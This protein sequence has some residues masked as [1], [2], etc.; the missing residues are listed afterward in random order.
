MPKHS[1]DRE[2]L[3]RYF[4]G[5]AS[6][7]ECEAV[8]EKY[9]AVYSSLEAFLR[10]ED[11]VID[12][13]VRGALNTS[14]R[15]LFE[16]NFLCTTARRQRLEFTKSLVEA[17]AG[18]ESSDLSAA[19]QESQTRRSL[20]TGRSQNEVKTT[21]SSVTLQGQP[22]PD[23][24][25]EWFENLLQWLD[26]VRERA[27]EKY[28]RIRDSLIRIFVLGGCVDAEDLADETINRVSLR[29]AQLMGTY[30]GDPAQYFT[31]VARSV[32]QESR[33]A[34]ATMPTEV[35]TE[36]NQADGGKKPERAQ[37]CLEKC[38]GQLSERNRELMLQYY[39]SGKENNVGSRKALAQ[40]LEISS[41]SLRIQANRIR[42]SL[43]KC[44]ASCLKR[45]E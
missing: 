31:A 15:V 43:K 29:S 5:V 45:S 32:L 19:H 40:R 38:L 28:E 36:K 33:R 30:A 11:E 10:A 34:R 14:E 24:H 6:T 21:G 17:L 42:T 27:A 4:L 13:Y 1:D 23:Y 18:V 2:L 35:V 25:L 41:S 22:V 3:T 26:P 9:L 37:K 8:E 44:V 7:D 20:V 12:D 16:E 39:S